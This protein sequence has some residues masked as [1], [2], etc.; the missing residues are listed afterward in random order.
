MERK[1]RASAKMKEEKRVAP[2]NQL[3]KQNEIRSSLH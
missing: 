2:T 1:E 3:E